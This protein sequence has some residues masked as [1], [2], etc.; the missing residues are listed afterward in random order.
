MH[1]YIFAYIYSPLTPTSPH[2]CTDCSRA[3]RLGLAHIYI[4]M[5]IA[6]I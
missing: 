6:N 5:H 2:R 3:F 1:R 4:Y